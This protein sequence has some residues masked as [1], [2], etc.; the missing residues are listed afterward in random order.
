MVLVL[1]KPTFSAVCQRWSALIFLRRPGSGVSRFAGLRGNEFAANL[2]AA[3]SECRRAAGPEKAHWAGH[4]ACPECGSCQ[5][6][7]CLRLTLPGLL[8][9]ILRDLRQGAP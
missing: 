1:F 4:M 5:V 8:T 3:H 2:P 6:P 7:G 9:T